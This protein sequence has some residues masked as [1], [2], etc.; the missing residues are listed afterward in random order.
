MRENPGITKK[1]AIARA[2]GADRNTVIKY[3]DEIVAE[4]QQERL[5]AERL[6]QLERDGH[7]AVKITPSQKLSDYILGELK[8]YKIT[9]FVELENKVKAV[10]FSKYNFDKTYLKEEYVKKRS[11][12]R[13]TL[14]GMY[15]RQE[16]FYIPDELDTDIVPEK[17]GVIIVGILRV[18]DFYRIAAE[19]SIMTGNVQDGIDIINESNYFLNNFIKIHSYY[20]N[21]R[22]NAMFHFWCIRIYE[23]LLER[24][25]FCDSDMRRFAEMIYSSLNNISE[26]AKIANEY[27]MIRLL[28]DTTSRKN[29]KFYK[30]LMVCFDNINSIFKHRDRLEKLKNAYSCKET[31][32][33]ELILFSLNNSTQ[34][35]TRKNSPE[36]I[37][38]L[39][40]NLEG[41]VEIYSSLKKSAAKTLILSYSKKYGKSPKT[42]ADF[43]EC[44]N[45]PAEAM[46]DTYTGDS[47]FSMD[48]LRL[49]KN[50]KQEK[51]LP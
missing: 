21:L 51:Q 10:D 47:F 20:V 44:F 36:S 16:I 8:K 50:T 5:R 12:L 43:S 7:I 23:P 48:F 11:S 3:Y 14:S 38:V 19:Y 26:N 40:K 41:T 27:A 35:K 24:M 1:A 49:P 32:G 29:L 45:L 30:E 2:V 4:L 13:K 34:W 37:P 6:E 33:N 17:L 9:T 22:A 18:T 28:E 46:T 39:L 25:P 15:G 31:E 42:A